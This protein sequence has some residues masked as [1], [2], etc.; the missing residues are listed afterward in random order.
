[1]F[2]NP[3]ILKNGQA[4][5]DA[6]LLES[7]ADSQADDLM[8]GLI[9]YIFPVIDH[10]A[11]ARLNPSGD[12]VKESRLPGPIRAD[13]GPEL[14]FPKGQI[15]PLDGGHPTKMAMKVLDL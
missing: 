3:H 15:H 13:D 11:G 7:P 10:L 4:G 9:G 8:G 12:Y 1:L 6:A 14:V 2:C 5:E